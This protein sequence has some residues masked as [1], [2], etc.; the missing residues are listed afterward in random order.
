MPDGGT[1]WWTE[2][3]THHPEKARKFYTSVFGWTANVMSMV[4][5]S[6]APNPGEPSYTTFNKDG[7][8]SLG[9]FTL[10]GEMFKNVPDHWFTYFHSADV[11]ASVKAIVAAGG[12]VQRPPWDVPGVGRMAIVGDASGAVFGLGKP[13]MMAPAP[14]KTAAPKAKKAKS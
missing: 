10:D 14:A 8:P 6:R 11:D 9:C 5:M 13:A 2:L 4:D 3:N 1:V 12:K 7:Q